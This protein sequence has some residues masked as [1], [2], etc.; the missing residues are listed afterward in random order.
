MCAAHAPPPPAPSS[1]FVIFHVG[2]WQHLLFYYF[3]LVCV[4]LC[5][6]DYDS[7]GC[8]YLHYLVIDSPVCVSLAPSDS[9]SAV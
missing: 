5:L 4:S 8:V 3:P 7:L 1:F 6:A 9:S 2:R